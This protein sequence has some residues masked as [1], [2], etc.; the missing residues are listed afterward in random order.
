MKKISI[1]A[2]A[3]LLAATALVGCDGM[4]STA[5]E[6]AEDTISSY[7]GKMFGY[8]IHQEM[9]KG[10][11]SA[12]FDE[13]SF[14]KGFELVMT[15][16]T[17]DISFIRGLQVGAQMIN[18]MHQLNQTDNIELNQNIMLND[19][20]EAFLSDSA[21]SPT[22]YQMELQALLRRVSRQKKEQNPVAIANKKA[23]KEFID[24]L[25][26][27][28]PDIKV[29]ESGLA[30]KVISEGSGE[31]F[32]INNRIMVKYRGTH[33]DG[34]EFDKSEEAKAMS[35]R[36][37]VKGFREGLTM[38]KPGAK[39]ILYIPGDLA[40]GLEGGARGAIEPNETLIFEVETEGLAPEKE[41]SS[42]KK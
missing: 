15:S 32:D 18:V 3:P 38:M 8:G 39:Y 34:T 7:Y 23:G 40:Y 35:P 16:D 21:G 17:S 29:T 42:K 30:Y 5:L 28:D 41:K 22:V 37:T 24:N 12:K 11:D 36:G 6:T 27:N 2:A 26:K 25:V 1:L 4:S 14:I 9:L 20:K 13:D 19:F 33:I 31:Q 10:P